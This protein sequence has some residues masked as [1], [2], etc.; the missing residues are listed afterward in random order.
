LIKKRKKKKE[1]GELP[2][3]VAS[4]RYLQRASPRRSSKITG[5]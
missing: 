2:T 4:L 3:V 5:Q 1:K